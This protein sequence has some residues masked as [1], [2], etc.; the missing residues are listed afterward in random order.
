MMFDMA[1]QCL[2]QESYE[3][4]PSTCASQVDVI[5]DL[6]LSQWTGKKEADGM[7]LRK[8]TLQIIGTFA[9]KTAYS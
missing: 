6:I 7:S 9:I 8:D 4:I 2:S 5:N 1:N 3:N